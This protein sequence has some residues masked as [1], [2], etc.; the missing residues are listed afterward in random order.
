MNNF[1]DVI[2]GAL[3]QRV[4][5]SKESPFKVNYYNSEKGKLLILTGDNAEGKSLYS[6]IFESYCI[7]FVKIECMRIGMDFRMEGG[8]GSALIYGFSEHEAS[9]G[10]NSIRSFLGG[11][12]TCK[13]RD[14]RHFIVF[15]EPGIGV[16]EEYHGAM[17]QYLLEFM[18]KCPT[19][20]QGV[21]ISTHS[22]EFVKP[23]LYLKPM[24]LRFGDKKTLEE[25]VNENIKPHTVKKLLDFNHQSV[26]KLRAACEILESKQK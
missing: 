16:S 14:H 24:H 6:R 25:W 4:F 9:T 21:V 8:V 7:K 5:K 10:D 20:T 15:D 12:N 11:L 19:N 17:G 23:L 13:N 26:L 18:Q 1:Y 2:S 3:S 22:R